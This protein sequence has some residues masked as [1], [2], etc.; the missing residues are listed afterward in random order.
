MNTIET[1]TIKLQIFNWNNQTARADKSKD[2]I[3]FTKFM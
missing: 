1:I 3:V 2:E